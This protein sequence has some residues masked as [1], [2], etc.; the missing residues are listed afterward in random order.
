MV[1]GNAYF[2]RVP[3]EEL[4]VRWAQAS[5]LMPAVQLSIAPWDLGP[6]AAEL[7]REA[8]ALR[9]RCAG[10][11]ER[12]AHEAASALVPICRPMWMLDP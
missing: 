5:A 7:V 3:D 6:R 1:G 11:I 9:T 10:L 12:L 4:M 2:G 8:L